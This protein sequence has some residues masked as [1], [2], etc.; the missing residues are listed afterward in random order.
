MNTV[1]AQKSFSNKEL[2]VAGLKAA[3][4]ILDK[5]GCSAEQAQAILRMK[6]ATYFKLKGDP[7]GANL[8]AD[9]LSRISMLLNIHQALRIVFE[10]PENQYGFMKM[11]NHNP[12]FSGRTPME[13]IEGG[14][15]TK[16]YETFK[17]VDALRGGLV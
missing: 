15:F 9:Q 11:K 3:F 16:L 10:N 5:W 12:Y 17:R 4:N 13:V 6:R 1:K 2:S 7:A 14:E 8:D